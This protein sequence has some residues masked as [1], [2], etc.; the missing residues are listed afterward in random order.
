MNK[1]KL[2]YE[3]PCSEVLVVRFEGTLLVVSDGVNYGNTPGGAG[4]DDSYGPNDGE[5]F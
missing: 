1:L 2:N 3:Q 4:G 5:G